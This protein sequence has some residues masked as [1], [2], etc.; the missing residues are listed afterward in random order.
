VPP[1]PPEPKARKSGEKIR[2]QRLQTFAKKRVKRHEFLRRC[3]LKYN[4]K[5][6]NLRICRWH[7]L[8]ESVKKWFSYT[9]PC[10][11]S[12]KIC[13]QFKNELPQ[14]AGPKSNR[15]G[16]KTAEASKGVAKDRFLVNYVQE[17]VAT[18][19]NGWKLAM[20]Q[21]AAVTDADTD[22]S[23]LSDRVKKR[24]SSMF[25]MTTMIVTLRHR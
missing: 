17:V 23:T 11:T 22:L 1:I 25:T 7:P 21:F 24:C 14:E 12:H 2:L 19:E 4:D 13:C 6:K 3:G 10:G 16:A 9:D 8:E 18:D 15:P 5:R 20:Q